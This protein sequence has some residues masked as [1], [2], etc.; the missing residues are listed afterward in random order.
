MAVSGLVTLPAWVNGWNIS[1]LGPSASLPAANETLLGEIVE[2]IIPET[3]TPGAKSLNVHHFVHR[4]IQDCYGEEAQH[5]LAK[6]LLT[7]DEIAKGA[8][9]KT[10]PEGDA[11]QRTAVMAHIQ[12][13]EDAAVQQFIQLI[14]NL[15]MQGYL[16][17]EYVLTHILDYNMAPG[18]YHGCVPVK[19]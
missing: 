15:T 1:S 2:T 7:V 11:Q 19:T 14:K 4:M 9:N 16:N 8:F 18:F 17:S 5:I 6:G 12:V 10:F 3:D 13:S